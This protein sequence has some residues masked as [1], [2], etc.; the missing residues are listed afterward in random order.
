M[1]FIPQQCRIKLGC[2]FPQ[3]CILHV[4]SAIRYDYCQVSFNTGSLKPGFIYSYAWHPE[5]N[6]SILI[7]ERENMSKVHHV[8]LPYAKMFTHD[9]NAFEDTTHVYLDTLAY[10]NADAYLKVPFIKEV[11]A[12]WCHFYKVL[13]LDN[14]DGR[15]S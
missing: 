14:V 11:I 5:V 9:L 7:F 3:R 8:Y 12:G 13:W 4:I 1:L 2:F 10:D 6:T 15:P